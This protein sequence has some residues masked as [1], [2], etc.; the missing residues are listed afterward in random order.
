VNN[1]FLLLEIKMIPPYFLLSGSK[2]IYINI[3]HVGVGLATA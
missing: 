1:V 3:I 2:A